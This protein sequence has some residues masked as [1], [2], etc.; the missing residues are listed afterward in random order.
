MHSTGPKLM[1]VTPNK[2][3]GLLHSG[4]S[5]T[6]IAFG[7]TNIEACRAKT[8]RPSITRRAG[9]LQ[10]HPFRFS[11]LQLLQPLRRLS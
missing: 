10:N 5:R 6:L 8:I 7:M 9:H 2:V 3:R 1:F 11:L 4:K